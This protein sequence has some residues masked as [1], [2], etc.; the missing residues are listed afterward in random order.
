MTGQ[1]RT[2]L[3]TWFALIF[4]AA[5]AVASQVVVE[6]AIQRETVAPT[7]DWIQSP[8]LMRRL[9][10][11]FDTLLADVYW[12]RSV[13][14]YGDTKLSSEKKKEYGRLFPLLDMTTTLDPRFNIAYRF[15]AILLSEGYPNGAG[16]TE[17]AI[18]LLEKAIKE[19]PE[20]WQYLHDAGFVE[21][22]WNKDPNAAAKWLLRAADVP[23]S[24]SWLR[25]VAAGML[26]E[27]GDERT[28]RALWTELEASAEHDWLRQAARRGLMQLDAEAAIAQL[29]PA[30]NRFHDT[31]G[32]FPASWQ[33]MVR[34]R[35]LPGIPL[36]P[37][38]RPF[39]LDPASGAIDVDRE[40]PV[41]PLRRS[42]TMPRLTQ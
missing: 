42:G 23:G 8:Q 15:G 22:W 4:L 14:Y 20:K 17:Q 6:G 19:M 30:V 34:E 33:E 25:P 38:G 18:A 24:P 2:T 28:S 16:N 29:Q 40:S 5:G 32:H 10:L 31:T 3:R 12:I 7:V 39:T 36:D 41:F 27:G 21:Y 9:A 26:A 1:P 37:S 11:S 13:Q 35:L